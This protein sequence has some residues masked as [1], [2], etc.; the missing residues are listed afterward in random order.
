MTDVTLFGESPFDSIKHTDETGE[1]WSAR[2][3][4]PL[5][6]Y[7]KWERFEDA[8]DRARAAAA[9]AGRGASARRRDAADACR[10]T[11]PSPGRTRSN[12][13]GTRTAGGRSRCG[14]SPTKRPCLDHARAPT[15][16]TSRSAPPN[17]MPATSS[18]LR[19]LWPPLFAGARRGELVGF[20]RPPPCCFVGAPAGEEPPE[21]GPAWF[22]GY[23]RHSGC[24]DGSAGRPARASPA[25]VVKPTTRQATT[26]RHRAVLELVAVGERAR[27]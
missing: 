23:A 25:V 17:A 27:S 2:E 7:E 3:L 15:A 6:G 11:P 14:R 21:R 13:R 18:A 12:G 16:S 19:D 9:N 10:N 26:T 24:G 20:A 22:S 5:L 1:W 4:M 8:V